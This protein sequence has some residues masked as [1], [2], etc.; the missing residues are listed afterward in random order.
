M[1]MKINQSKHNKLPSINGHSRV[2]SRSFD[3]EEYRCNNYRI[4]YL[5]RADGDK[6]NIRDR[7]RKLITKRPT[8]EELQKKGIIK[9]NQIKQIC[10]LICLI[11]VIQ[12]GIT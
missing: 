11:M 7:L 3:L 12:I 6:K 2:F 4:I 1:S 5:E 10:I 9:G 8:F